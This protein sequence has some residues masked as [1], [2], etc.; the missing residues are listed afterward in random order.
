[1]GCCRA[2]KRKTNPQPSGLSHL[3]EGLRRFS[4]EFEPYVHDL[5]TEVEIKLPA[6]K[7]LQAISDAC[8]GLLP[9]RQVETVS[10]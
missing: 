8:A 6:S 5:S 4:E 3:K 10:W 2:T 1:M 7:T 9:L